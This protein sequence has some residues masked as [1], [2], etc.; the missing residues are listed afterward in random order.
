M[1]FKV[2]RN[3]QINPAHYEIY[4][5][6]PNGLIWR[7]IEERPKGLSSQWSRFLPW[8]YTHSF[9][10]LL[11]GLPSS[12]RP[13]KKM[14]EGKSIFIWPQKPHQKQGWGISFPK[15]LLKA[16]AIRASLVKARVQKSIKK[17]LS[18]PEGSSGLMQNWTGSFLH[19]CSSRYSESH[20]PHGT[21]P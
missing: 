2:L 3:Y 6:L 9:L 14:G 17:E 8:S 4:Y 10:F 15:A 5:F 12:W 20:S 19:S 16:K 13:A 18:L 1:D 7:E 11:R 21:F